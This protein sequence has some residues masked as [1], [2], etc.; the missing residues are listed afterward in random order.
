MQSSPAY[1]LSVSDFTATS[2]TV[3]VQVSKNLHSLEVCVMRDT[4]QAGKELLLAPISG[5]LYTLHFNGLR[6]GCIYRVR[7]Q[8]KAQDGG[9][10]EPKEIIAFTQAAEDDMG[11]F[12]FSG[13]S[14][15][16][17]TQ[18][19]TGVQ[20]TTTVKPA[21]RNFPK[22]KFSELAG[23]S[24]S[25]KK[26]GTTFTSDPQLIKMAGGKQSLQKA[27]I[28]GRK[29]PSLE[30]YLQQSYKFS[31]PPELQ[32]ERLQRAL[33][34]GNALIQMEREGLANNPTLEE[35]EGFQLFQNN[36]GMGP[37]YIWDKS[38]KQMRQDRDR[39]G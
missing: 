4:Q 30:S 39:A 29:A 38:L 22:P 6:P 32:K 14:N 1:T 31:R 26:F 28:A 19:R 25:E 7:A 12:G 18:G 15:P 34:Y 23:L 11:D 13:Q 33:V 21:G 36:W 35:S 9:R 24:E 8:G 5:Q 37:F 10:L 2:L 3:D 20:K 16:N 27:L 17:Q